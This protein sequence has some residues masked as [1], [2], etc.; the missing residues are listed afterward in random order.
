M[1]RTSLILAVIAL[2]MWVGSTWAITAIPGIIF[3]EI[4]D[5]TPINLSF[6]NDFPDSLG[7][8]PISYNTVPETASVTFYMINDGFHALPDAGVLI[9]YEDQAKTKVSDYLI[10]N[11]VND[12]PSL[13]ERIYNLS[14]V[15]GSKNGPPLV[16]PTGTLLADPVVKDGTVQLLYS[17]NYF[18]IF[19]K[20][21]KD[22]VTPIP[23]ILLLL[24]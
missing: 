13:S 15:S 24:E 4:S 11:I 7:S 18:Q 14:F 16:P 8:N 10:L 3:E 12:I 9:M 6:L 2:L 20:S 22:I 5:T 17:N 19:A 23:C 21:V 1:K